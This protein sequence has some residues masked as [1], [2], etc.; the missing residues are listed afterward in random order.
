M[1]S[2]KMK[3][4]IYPDRL[5]VLEYDAGSAEVLGSEILEYMYGIYGT[6]YLYADIIE[7]ACTFGLDRKDNQSSEIG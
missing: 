1:S 5:Y 3:Y 6:D 4:S 2:H 7:N